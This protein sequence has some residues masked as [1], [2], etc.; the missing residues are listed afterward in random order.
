MLF[1]WICKQRNLEEVL[2]LLHV[3]AGVMHQ[4]GI[5]LQILVL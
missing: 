2:I 3:L 1:A 5:T 4:T